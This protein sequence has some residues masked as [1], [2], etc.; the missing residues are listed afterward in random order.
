[1]FFIPVFLATKAQKLFKK[2]CHILFYMFFH[3]F[4]KNKFIHFKQI[5]SSTEYIEICH[6][7]CDS[8][9]SDFGYYS[10]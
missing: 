1:M 6:L 9:V 7:S 4:I 5:Y 8:F 3:L 10:R 2:K